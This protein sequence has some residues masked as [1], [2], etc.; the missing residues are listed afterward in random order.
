MEPM[1]SA[2]HHFLNPRAAQYSVEAAGSINVLTRAVHWVPILSVIDL[3]HTIHPT[4]LRSILIL[5]YHLHLPS[6]A[7]CM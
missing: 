3:V 6:C 2:S 4:S 1:L 7:C 5:S